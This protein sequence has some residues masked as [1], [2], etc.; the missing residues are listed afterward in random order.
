MFFKFESFTFNLPLFS[1]RN[2]GLFPQ[3]HPISPWMLLKMY[4]FNQFHPNKCH[5][6]LCNKNFLCALLVYIPGYESYS[7]LFTNWGNFYNF[8]HRGTIIQNSAIYSPK[9]LQYGFKTW[10]FSLLGLILP[11]TPKMYSNFTRIILSNNLQTYS[12][13]HSVNQFA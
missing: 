8:H 10:V 3:F 12:F 1:C 6:N 4:N 9:Y 5:F 11:N 7:N 13:R 2:L